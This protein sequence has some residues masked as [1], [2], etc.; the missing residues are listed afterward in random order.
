MHRQTQNKTGDTS[1]ILG[2][3]QVRLILSTS[4]KSSPIRVLCDTGSQ[5]NLITEN[6]VQQ[7]RLRR[8]KQKILISGIGATTYA[9]GYVDVQITHRHADAASVTA[10]ML[11]V[12]KISSHIPDT[13]F[14][15]PFA[16]LIDAKS[17]ADPEYNSPAPV[18]A[19]IGVGVWSAIILGE[20][21][22]IV[23]KDQIFLA[24]QSTLGWIISGQSASCNLLQ[25]KTCMLDADN[26]KV[27]AAIRKLW[28]IEA[29]PTK[30]EWSAEERLAEQIFVQTQQ[31]DA[32]GRYI[33]RI[34]RK[35]NAPPLGNSRRAAI[36]C[37]KQLERR[38]AKDPSLYHKY[39]Q[40][41][42]DYRSNGHLQ[43]ASAVPTGDANM[44]VMPH[45]AINK[46][47]EKK[48]KFRVVFNA[49][50]KTE[51]GIS[52]N[53]QQ[54]IGPKLQADLC[55]LFLRFRF[56]R[57]AISADIHQMFRQIKIH[58]EDWSYQR[59]VRRVRSSSVRLTELPISQ[60][61]RKS[62]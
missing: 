58:K 48:G 49:S 30:R 38:F 24:Q 32:D 29:I 13:D 60:S 42:D 6:C 11:V 15:N 51:S 44:Y 34:P 36:A 9:N 12:S 59:I 26:A 5:P 47:D 16:E 52:F 41:I 8:I 53:D 40:V 1:G 3:A 14:E 23:V 20:I 21:Q 61:V 25:V 19:L 43:L 2:T 4:I 37:F 33:V 22:R 55:E 10:R 56:K 57:Y 39:R 54:L 27:D 17:Y 31:R 35:Q 50:A 7:L 46:D 62:C 18:D 45:H 28:E